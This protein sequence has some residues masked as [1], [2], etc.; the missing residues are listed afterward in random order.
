MGIRNYYSQITSVSGKKGHRILE[1]S[2]E[3]LLW[4]LGML[5]NFP[6][7]PPLDGPEW[8]VLIQNLQE[9]GFTG[10]LYYICSKTPMDMRPPDRIWKELTRSSHQISVNHLFYEQQLATIE[11]ELKK[12]HIRYLLV[13]GMALGYQVY[14]SPT[15]RP[16]RDIDLLIPHENIRIASDIFQNMGYCLMF[17]GYN[18][19][20]D[21]YHHQVL[22]PPPGCRYI[23]VEIHWRP[24]N[25]S[26]EKSGIRVDALFGSSC[27]ITT[28]WGS[29]R[30]FSLEDALLYAS[31]HM[32]TQHP[33]EIR[34]IW[35]ADIV[36]LIQA[37]SKQDLWVKVIERAPL[38]KGGSALARTLELTSLWFGVSPPPQGDV[39]GSSASDDLQCL[40]TADR[41]ITRREHKVLSQMHRMSTLSGKF[42]VL[43]HYFAATRAVHMICESPSLRE[44]GKI[45][46][47]ILKITLRTWRQDSQR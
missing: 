44:Y 36:F 2:D 30:T 23:S 21:L 41:I 29:F 34:L 37:I 28:L 4:L 40:I 24:L 22:H 15:F 14:P 26:G 19:S 47:S 31:L 39:Y 9:Q 6:S 7:P 13:K 25:N 33:G 42:L 10:Y 3:M 32:C 43:F 27:L 1:L 8:D 5:S 16:F 38:W 12:A 45:W 46:F 11:E 18:V 20:S 17:D 35:M